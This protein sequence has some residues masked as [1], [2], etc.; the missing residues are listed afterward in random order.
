MTTAEKRWSAYK[1]ARWSRSADPASHHRHCCGFLGTRPAGVACGCCSY[2][3]T[4]WAR[5]PYESHPRREH[6]RR[7]RCLGGHRD[8]EIES[9]DCRHPEHV[10]KKVLSIFVTGSTRASSSSFGQ[11]EPQL[12]GGR[13]GCRILGSWVYLDFP[14]YP[15]HLQIGVRTGVAVCIACCG[16]NDIPTALILPSTGSHLPPD[17][18]LAE[19]ILFYRQTKSQHNSYLQ[20]L[21]DGIKISDWL[22]VTSISL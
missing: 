7:S 13:C 15:K 10:S 9:I 18:R 11:D 2:D 6:G 22:T 16:R 21:H 19:A 8:S 17:T 12:R 14:P 1:Q 3:P 20:L 4:W 5:R